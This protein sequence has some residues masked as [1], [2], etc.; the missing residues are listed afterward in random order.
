MP[1]KAINENRD[2]LLWEYYIR[3]AEKLVLP[4]PSRNFV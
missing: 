1:E 3:A 4:A 2:P